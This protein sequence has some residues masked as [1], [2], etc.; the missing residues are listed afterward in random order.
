MPTISLTLPV[1]GTTVTAGLHAGNYTTLQTLLNGG[2]DTANWAPGK[3]FAPSK[4]VQEGAIDQDI[5]AWDQATSIY[6]PKA[7]SILGK[8]ALGL[9][10]VFDRV[11]TLTDIQNDATEKDIYRKT[12]TGNLLGLK[13]SAILI[14][15]GDYKHNNVAGDTITIKIKYGA[16]TL[17]ADTYNLGNVLGAQIHGYTLIIDLENLNATNSQLLTAYGLFELANVGAPTTGVGKFGAAGAQLIALGIASEDSTADKDL[18]VTV[19]WSA[20]NANNSWRVRS[21]KMVLV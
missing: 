6:K 9:A 12:I 7:A 4:F 1:S 5:I 11:S 2:L 15:K 13:R 16:T 21:A 8:A 18:A 10:E 14:L 3:I 20:A 19:Q 17:W